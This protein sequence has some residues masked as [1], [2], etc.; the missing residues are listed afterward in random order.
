MPKVS[1]GIMGIVTKSP[2]KILESEKR[3]LLREV[4]RLAKNANSR[5]ARLE[6]TNMTTLPGYASWQQDGSV[7]FGVRGKTIAQ[8]Q[9][10]FWRVS[11]FL[12]AKT[13]TVKG[14]RNFLEKAGRDT[15]F[16]SSGVWAGAGADK[17]ALL[18][19][20]FNYSE[21][22]K[23]YLQESGYA[24]EALAYR[25]IWEQ[26]NQMV[27]KEMIDIRESDEDAQQ[28]QVKAVMEMALEGASEV[29]ADWF[30]GRDLTKPIPPRLDV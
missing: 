19:N 16:G 6:R 28:A 20:Y 26:V 7:R 27:E 3:Q 4:S 18:S 1:E 12:D 22:V 11:N 8:V 21:W 14:A 25:E 30:D 10:E 23:Q 13:T 5:L 29:F 15:G 9:E 24:A 2:E 17:A